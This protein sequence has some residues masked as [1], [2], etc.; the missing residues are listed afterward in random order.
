[1]G[2]AVHSSDVSSNSVTVIFK[3][4]EN[5][6]W[7]PEFKCYCLDMAPNSDRKR[8]HR[9]VCLSSCSSSEDSSDDDEVEEIRSYFHY[10]L[11]IYY[12]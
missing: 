2:W 12:L 4:F 11:F 3:F 7:F 10:Q 8:K 6:R 5:P 1:M 9:V